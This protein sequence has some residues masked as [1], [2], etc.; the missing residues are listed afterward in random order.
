LE[1]LRQWLAAGAEGATHQ[2]F[3]VLDAEERLIGVV[4]RRDLVDPANAGSLT[5]R[6]IVRRPPVVVF[7]DSTLRDAAD[8]MVIEHVGRLPVVRREALRNVV[9]I[10]SRSDLLSAHAPRLEAAHRLRM[11]RSLWPMAAQE[12]ESV[13]V[14]KT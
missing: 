10:I 9:G 1:E 14:G 11:A 4:T 8:Q 2:G 6:E 13:E 7:E 12:T 5:V 3:P